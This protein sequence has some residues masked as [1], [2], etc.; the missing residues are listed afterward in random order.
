MNTQRVSVRI[1]VVAVAAV[2]FGALVAAEA[3]FAQAPPLKLPQPSQAA[4]VSQTVGLTEI[5]VT[6]H[7][8]RVRGRKIWGEVVPYGEVWRAG[9]NENTTVE[10]SSDVTVAG[11]PLAAGRY[12]FHLLPAETG[13]WTAIFSRT[14]TG[15]GSFGYDQT[16]D[17]LRVAVKPEAAPLEEALAY[18]FDD[19]TDR[20]TT[21]A[22]RWEKLRV[23]LAIQVDTPEVVY[24]SLRRELRGLP[25]FF[26]QPWN[27]AANALI[28]QNVH[29][30]EA[31]GWADRSIAIQKNFPNVHTKSRLLAAKGDAAAAKKLLDEALPTATEAELNAYGYQLLAAGKAADAVAVF[32]DVVKRHPESWNARDS[33]GEGLEALGDTSASISSYEQALSMAPEAQRSRIQGILERLRKKS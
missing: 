22:L 7:R 27:Q 31:L 24:Q 14:D 23:P 29:L 11:Q 32:R 6:Y 12:G 18:T 28:A 9:A 30:D 10:F 17:A 26:W 4:T 33:L 19:A 8:P 20:A 21:L 5:T 2:A 16:E 15:W 1:S 13:D 3:A 25:Q